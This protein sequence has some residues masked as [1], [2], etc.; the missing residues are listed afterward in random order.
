MRR[1]L[2]HLLLPHQEKR[3][4]VDPIDLDDMPQAGELRHGVCE[5]A[6]KHILLTVEMVT[7][8]KAYL[9]FVLKK[10]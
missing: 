3:F 8:V 9:T 5:N 2:L 4:K 1:L 10:N 7:G 6:W